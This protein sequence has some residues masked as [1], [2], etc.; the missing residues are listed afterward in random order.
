MKVVA[1]LDAINNGYA[2]FV[3][4]E[5]ER[6]NVDVRLKTLEKYTGEPIEEA[7][8]WELTFSEGKQVLT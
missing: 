5:G 4:G 7:T 3:Y 1:A 6:E 2:R 8:I